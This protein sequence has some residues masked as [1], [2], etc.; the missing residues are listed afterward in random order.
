MILYRNVNY[1]CNKLRTKIKSME[2]LEAFLRQTISHDD[3]TTGLVDVF[4]SPHMRT[5]VLEK[6]GR[7]THQQLLSLAR[8]TGINALE[9]LNKW[10][11]GQCNVSELEK[12]NL[13]QLYEICNKAAA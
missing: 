1:F 2:S 12:Q 9:L 8:L 5:K 11:V 10:A 3:F 6:P 7:A 4:G 13:E